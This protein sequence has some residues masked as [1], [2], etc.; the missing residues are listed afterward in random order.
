MNSE[1]GNQ[2]QTIL[3]L[4]VIGAL[5]APLALVLFVVF[6]LIGGLS[7]L[8]LVWAVVLGVIG[9]SL[10][11]WRL[12]S[13]AV[14]SALAELQADPIEP[15][16]EPRLV[17]LVEGLALSSG[18]AQP[19]LY[20]IDDEA[21]N[22]CVLADQNRAIMVLTSGMLSTLDRIQLE[23]VVA[24]ALARIRS[25]DAASATVAR[26]LFGALLMEPFGAMVEPIAKAGLER[27][28]APHSDINTDQAAV[29]IT[30]Y[31]PGLAAAL[32]AL[33]QK[34]VGPETASRAND[35]LWLVSPASAAGRSTVAPVSP[36]GLRID[37]LHEL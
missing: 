33:A 11:I 29:T 5:A 8:D 26:T 13:R 37:V 4:V 21:C 27:L 12:T 15:A 22:S 14:I 7:A 30:R 23:A 19:E 34:P 6:A 28:I 36:L 17:N 3:T 10:V 35:H 1:S 16:D 20:L 2:S 31:P 32:E 25:G 18:V 9:A 24:N